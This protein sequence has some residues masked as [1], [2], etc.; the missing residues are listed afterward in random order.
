MRR[1]SG[2]VM[3][4]LTLAGCTYGGGDMADPLT[5][6][7]HW[8]S[9]VAGDD[10]RATCQAGTPDRFRLVYNGVYDQQLRLYEVDSVRR[11]LSVKVT[12]PGNASRLSGDDLLAPWR[13]VEGSVPLEPAAYAQLVDDFTA[14]G[15]FGPPAIG[16]ELPSR[17]YHWSAASCK[18]G[19]FRF[20]GWTYPDAGF[21]ALPFAVT[22]FAVDPTGVAVAR[23]G[24]I[25]VDPQYEEKLR[26]GEVTSFSLKV[27][28]DGMVR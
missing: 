18:D 3:V 4:G 5:R 10:I 20:T 16:R 11:L 27:G 8:F 15:L 22:L 21:E 7:F 13:A 23:P 25:A 14:A 26:R 19:R 1:I 9:Y 28:A 12:A 24:P 6:K 2:V 17:G